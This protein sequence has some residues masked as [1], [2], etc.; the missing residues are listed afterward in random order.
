[1][2]HRDSVDGK[3]EVT[4]NVTQNS[5]NT[6]NKEKL[7]N[8]VFKPDDVREEPSLTSYDEPDSVLTTSSLSSSNIQLGSDPLSKPPALINERKVHS[9]Q[10][11]PYMNHS[12]SFDIG[13]DTSERSVSTTALL[14]QREHHHH[15]PAKTVARYG[16]HLTLED[17]SRLQRFLEEFVTKGL[18]PHLEQLTRAM[19]ERVSSEH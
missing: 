1:L 7:N 18:L 17:H 3:Q 12:K 10:S 19:N 11:S 16:A 8:V 9:A 4:S 15:Q 14:E 13:T 5:G 6:I 2:R